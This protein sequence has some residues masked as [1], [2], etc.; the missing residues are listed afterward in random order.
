MPNIDTD[1]LADRLSEDL[2]LK[3]DMGR[4]YI[5]AILPLALLMDRK[6]QDYGSSNISTT[7]ELGVMVR[8]QDKVS[9]LRNL[10]AK[11][12]KSGELTTC[13]E[14]VE[15]SWSDLANY[16]VIGLLLRRGKWR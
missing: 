8:S 7:G 2:G 13:F 16:G 10:L 14:S 15:D 11:E 1:A 5:R 3:T 4:E 12:M 9:R 6:Q